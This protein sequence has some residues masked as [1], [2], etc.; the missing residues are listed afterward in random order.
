MLTYSKVFDKHFVTA[1]AGSSLSDSR[2]TLYGFT[3]QGFGAE[4]AAQPAYAHGYEEGGAPDNAEGH[5]RMA[6]FFASAN[7]AFDSRYL[8]DFSYRLDGSS[9]FGSKEKVAPFYSVG[10]GWNLHNEAFIKKLE[11]INM[12]KVRG[13]YG[14]T[15]SVNFT[16]YQ[17]RDMYQYT[18]NDRYDGN[19]GVTLLSL[20]NENLRWQTTRS[21]EVGAT[22]GLFD[23][24]DLSASFYN[25]TT[26]DMV[27]PVTTPPSVG[28]SSYTEN[29]G[30]MKNKGYELSL[31]AFVIKQPGFNVSLFASASHN[32]NKI[33]AI[34]SALESFNKKTDSSEGYTEQEYTKA[35]HKFLTRYEEGQSSTAIYAVRSLGIDPMT[36]EELFLTKNGKPTKVWNAENKVVVGDTE[37][38][39]RGTFGTNIGWKGLYVNATF[40]YS[41][42]GQAYNQT[43]VD[44]VENSNKFQNVD[45]RV[46]TETWK[47]PGDIAKYKANLTARYVQYFT[48]ASSRF[49]QDLNYLQLSS[50][51]L[52]YELPRKVISPLRMQSLRLS[53]NMSDILYLSTVK[54]ERGTSYPYARTF[55]LGLRANF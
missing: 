2:S 38:K 9:Q 11:F 44:K 27:L 23:R 24:I 18:K 8:F 22:V 21:Y 13:T 43:L 17:A 10:L 41:Y 30:K 53:F 47:K 39:V 12:F 52:Q 14:E 1:S 32:T 3:A 46:L 7:Y 26:S 34:S 36:G 50:L 35:S 31:R 33:L 42:G 25:K 45:K 6:S 15:G 16:P 5:A 51:S 19:I 54:R 49:V 20:G 40:S 37:P 48:Y 29:L 55:T 4:D 28:F